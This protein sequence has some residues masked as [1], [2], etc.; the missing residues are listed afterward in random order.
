MKTTSISRPALS[1]Q[2]EQLQRLVRSR[3]ICIPPNNR[4]IEYLSSVLFNLKCRRD[5]MK[6]FPQSFEGRYFVQRCFP[7]AFFHLL[8][9]GFLVKLGKGSGSAWSHRGANREL[10]KENLLAS[11]R[12]LSRAKGSSLARIPL[13]SFSRTTPWQRSK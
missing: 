12:E 11:F 4:A 10:G 9:H 1:E 7:G 3:P 13:E 2:S 5:V 8:L 6:R